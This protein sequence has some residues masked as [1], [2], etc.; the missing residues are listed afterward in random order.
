MY[1]I[2]DKIKKRLIVFE[3]HSVPTSAGKMNYPVI[4]ST[5]GQLIGNIQQSYEGVDYYSFKGIPYARPPI[6]PLR[7]QVNFSV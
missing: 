3:I 4:N 6:G 2:T 1:Q 7:F 5:A